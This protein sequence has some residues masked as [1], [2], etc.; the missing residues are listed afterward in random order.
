MYISDP[1]VLPIV[2]DCVACETIL[3]TSLLD[4][5]RRL[6]AGGDDVVVGGLGVLLGGK[7][8]RSAL[9]G[10]VGVACQGNLC[11]CVCVGRGGGVHTNTLCMFVDTFFSCV[12]KLICRLRYS[13]SA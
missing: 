8:G 1:P 13:G 2:Y 12:H 4:C 10:V 5:S 6:L 11:V 3:N 9:R 7:V